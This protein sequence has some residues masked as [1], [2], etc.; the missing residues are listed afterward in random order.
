MDSD[1]IFHLP[2]GPRLITRPSQCDLPPTPP[3]ASPASGHNRCCLQ[4]WFEE[5]ADLPVWK[6]HSSTRWLPLRWR[7]SPLTSSSRQRGSESNGQPKKINNNCASSY[8]PSHGIGL[9]WKQMSSLSAPRAVGRHSLSLSTSICVVERASP[10]A[11]QDGC[12]RRCSRCLDTGT[13]ALAGKPSIRSPTAHR[14]YCGTTQGRNRRLASGRNKQSAVSMG[15]TSC[16][17]YGGGGEGDGQRVLNQ[18]QTQNPGETTAT[19]T[20]PLGRLL[21]SPAPH[22]LAALSQPA[23]A[24]CCCDYLRIIPNQGMPPCPGDIHQPSTRWASPRVAVRTG[25]GC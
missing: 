10:N 16:A 8:V 18:P 2:S 15:A 21:I 4:G 13:E 23:Q 20:V 25:P 19:A 5:I 11:H 14:I 9:N 3:D 6:G 1:R 24:R 7:R 17:R 12:P 22:G